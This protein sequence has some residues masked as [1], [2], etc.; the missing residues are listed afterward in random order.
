[1]VLKCYQICIWIEDDRLYIQSERERYAIKQKDT[2]KQT[3]RHTHTHAHCMYV[4]IYQCVCVCVGV[5]PSLLFWPSVHSAV[6]PPS[7]HLCVSG[8]PSLRWAVSRSVGWSVCPPVGLSVRSVSPVSVG[9]LVGRSVH[10]SV[11]LSAVHDFHTDY[12]TV[13]IKRCNREGEASDAV[14][15]GLPQNTTYLCQLQFRSEFS[16]R[17]QDRLLNAQ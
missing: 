2:S 11:G 13:V 15:R 4:C 16:P 17:C 1:M 5:L 7:S 9:R 6:F 10:P 14:A 8:R 3:D 12:G